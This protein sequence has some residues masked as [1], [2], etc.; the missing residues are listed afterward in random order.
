MLFKQ[1]EKC[2]Y[3]CFNTA[4]SAKERTCESRIGL[5]TIAVGNSNYLVH[6]VSVNFYSTSAILMHSCELVFSIK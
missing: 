4:Y 2:T 3:I 1:R 5:M 6:V